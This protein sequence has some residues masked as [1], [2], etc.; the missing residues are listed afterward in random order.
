[1]VHVPGGAPKG[2]VVAASPARVVW[3]GASDGCSFED[4]DSPPE[5]TDGMRTDTRTSRAIVPP[6]DALK[7]VRMVSLPRG[8]DFPAQGDGNPRAKRDRP[9]QLAR[10]QERGRCRTASPAQRA[11]QRALPLMQPGV[12]E[13]GSAPLGDGMA[14]SCLDAT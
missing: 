4:C 3:L 8:T 1:M 5:T 9:R 13:Y 14:R 6:T 11:G 12:L 7:R 2:S 10:I